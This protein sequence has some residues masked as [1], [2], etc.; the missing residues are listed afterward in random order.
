[1]PPLGCPD[2]P[3]PHPAFAIHLARVGRLAWASAQLEMRVNGSGS[4]RVMSMQRVPTMCS[5]V[6]VFIAADAEHGHSLFDAG[7]IR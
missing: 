7:L 2:A 6:V 3:E 4:G 5:R 1:M